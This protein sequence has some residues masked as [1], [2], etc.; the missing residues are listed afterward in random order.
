MIS[1]MIV[2]ATSRGKPMRKTYSVDQFMNYTQTYHR[3]FHMG[4]PTGMDRDMGW[5]M[6]YKGKIEAG[7]KVP[8]EIVI[9]GRTEDR[10][11]KFV[12]VA[13]GTPRYLYVNHDNPE[14]HCFAYFPLK[15][16]IPG[17]PLK[18]VWK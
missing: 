2:A 6:E 3:G 7:R 16:Y 18:R 14:E 9:K 12:E 15:N 17:K 10:I 11:F 4:N 8:M 1:V 5:V 13:N